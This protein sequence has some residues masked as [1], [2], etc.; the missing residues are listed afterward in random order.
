MLLDLFVYHFVWQY[1]DEYYSYPVLSLSISLERKS[2][3]FEVN[4]I[5]PALLLSLLLIPM[6]IMPADAGEKVSLGN[7]ILSLILYCCEF[8]FLPVYGS[9]VRL[10]FI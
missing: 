2:K 3:Y 1:V 9:M 6:F 5:L 4:I 10:D 7:V 8:S